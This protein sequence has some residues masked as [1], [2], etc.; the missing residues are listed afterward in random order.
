V[1]DQ[2]RQTIETVRG[3]PYRVATWTAQLEAATAGTFQTGATLPVSLRWREQTARAVDPFASFFDDDNG[4]PADLRAWMKGLGDPF[5]AVHERELTLHTP[6]QPIE[7]LPLPEGGRPADF[8]GAVGQFDVRAT[9]P[10]AAT[11]LEPTT[12]TLAISGRGS[13]DR[14]TTSGLPS[15]PALKTYPPAARTNDSPGMRTFEQPIVPEAS[16]E[17]TI[18]PVAF[19]YFDPRTGRY[20]T[21]HSQPLTLQVAAA[22]SAS[23]TRPAAAGARSEW[24]SDRP[25]ATHASGRPPV[26]RRAWF[27]LLE[28]IPLAALLV[29][30]RRRSRG[31]TRRAQKRALAREIGAWR[32]DMHRAAAAA[33]SPR[34]FA[35][36]RAAVQLE[37]GRRWHVPPGDV[38]AALVRERLGAQ[39]EPLARA[40]TLAEE[41][42]YGGRAPD[43]RSLPEWN[44]A[45]AHTLEVRP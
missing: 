5:G 43:G 16:G 35:A 24:R 23:A 36:S 8:S 39:G 12:L 45:I 42:Q 4:P 1:S 44:T 25:L 34:F 15:S 40:L 6:V 31:H 32:A 11:Q 19:S 18:P 26:Y 7:V 37:L 3:L 9:V 27:W 17:Q 29:L 14:V 22:A 33:D 13:F 38:T 28:V 21:A 2:P 41:V 10:R 20:E 30:W